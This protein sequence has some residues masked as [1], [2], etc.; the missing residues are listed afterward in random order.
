MASRMPPIVIRQ[1]TP[2]NKSFTSLAKL[3]PECILQI[4]ECLQ[5]TSPYSLNNVVLTC[6]YLYRQARY[7]QYSFLSVGLG[8][9]D[10]DLL[11][12][13]PRN[14][15][16]ERL[17]YL[18]RNDMLAAVRILHV[19]ARAIDQPANLSD[20]RFW[21]W[22]SAAIPKMT[23]LRDLY[24]TGCHAIPGSILDALSHDLSQ[25]PRLRLH[26]SISCRI[27][28]F[29]DFAPVVSDLLFRL[30]GSPNLVDIHIDL[31]YSTTNLQAL[32]E[33]IMARLK[34]TLLS[35]PNLRDLS[36]NIW[37]SRGAPLN[38]TYHGIGMT[39]GEKL[40][41]L[42]SLTLSDYPWGMSY[43]KAPPDTP[44]YHFNGYPNNDLHE[45]EYWA[46]NCDWSH[47]HSLE[48]EVK[49]RLGAADDGPTHVLP[50]L[51]AP[52]LVSLT[53]VRCQ[54]V[55]GTC[56]LLQFFS[57]LPETVKL[58][59]LA[60]ED[61]SL[62]LSNDL[63][64]HRETITDLTLTPLRG[65]KL[66]EVASIAK[67]FPS[68]RSLRIRYWRTVDGLLPWSAF[69]ILA[70]KFPNLRDLTINL[71]SLNHQVHD[72]TAEPLTRATVVRPF[73]AMFLEGNKL[74]NFT[75]MC[76]EFTE[77][78]DLHPHARS[79]HNWWQWE[80]ANRIG[81]EG[82]RV[83]SDES[84]PVRYKVTC[85]G[86]SWGWNERLERIVMG[87]ESADLLRAQNED[88]KTYFK[89][90]VGKRPDR[91]SIAPHVF[92]LALDGPKPYKR[93]GYRP[94]QLDSLWRSSY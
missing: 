54:A 46:A 38:S 10:D 78:E 33:D 45:A 39:N 59:R 27:T 56:S 41:R 60:L 37:Y 81:F 52:K 70:T 18:V 65:V 30:Q 20:A 57:T 19:S 29:A 1:L 7:I 63:A 28:A 15:S 34:T 73:D 13:S 82:E 26:L 2:A 51:I 64:R 87:K 40:P 90:R 67:C 11:T 61:M 42:E 91:Q 55:E 94:G 74:E 43:A 14:R 88:A 5:Q 83:M 89:Y 49:R 24:W 47:L 16:I 84:S 92:W 23:G 50:C 22:V 53:S 44:V 48:F 35:C 75:L 86:L 25:R 66:D 72:R 3:S 9:D 8:P 62:A 76:G 68:L 21:E 12:E 85:M 36:L 71:I 93:D 4:F 17:R 69:E 80:T 6:S 58:Q 79:S 32:R 31:K 77:H